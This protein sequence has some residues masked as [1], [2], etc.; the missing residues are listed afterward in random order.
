MDLNICWWNTKLTPPV[1]KTIN[2]P[3]NPIFN[4]KVDAVINNITSERP[5]DLFILCEVYNQDEPLIEDIA[6]KNYLKHLMVTKHV[7]GVYYDFAILYEETKISI[8]NVEFINEKSNFRQQLR[9][10]AII[11][12]L[13]DGEEVSL[14]ISHWNSAMFQG[15]GK[16]EYCAGKLRDKIDIK[17]KHGE[18][19]IILLGDYNSQPFE[20]E[21]TQTLQTTKDLDI[22]LDAPSILYNPFWRNL[23]SRTS[24]HSFSGSYYYHD[25]D[26]D[27]WKTYD[28]MMFSSAFVYGKSWKLDIY[29]PEIHS[30]FNGLGFSFTDFFDHIPIHG[31]IRK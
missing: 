2:K 1:K 4:E 12:A 26:Y 5:V 3:V 21:I 17:I 20:K 18:S 22:I 13:F 23:D 11:D 16:K 30:C 28:Q 8:K 6:K 7:S 27:K 10:G 31:R 9:I 29:S 14:F 24:L 25:D 19:H 15:E